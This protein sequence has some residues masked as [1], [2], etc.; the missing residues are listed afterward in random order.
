[1]E[2]ASKYATPGSTLRSLSRQLEVLGVWSRT[3][4]WGVRRHAAI[5]P[6]RRA[7]HQDPINSHRHNRLRSGRR[8]SDSLPSECVVHCSSVSWVVASL[9]DGSFLALS[10]G[11]DSVCHLA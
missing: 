9:M 4:E 3:G 11:S 5:H 6:D 2:S 1:M 7:L 8:L 10:A